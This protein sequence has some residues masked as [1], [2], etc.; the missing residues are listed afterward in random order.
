MFDEDGRLVSSGG[1]SGTSQEDDVAPL[2][3]PANAPAPENDGLPAKKSLV[4]K[5]DSDEDEDFGELGERALAD[6]QLKHVRKRGQ[7]STTTTTPI[8]LSRLGHTV[9][10][11]RTVQ[12][13]SGHKLDMVLSD[14]TKRRQRID[15]T[16]ARSAESN[17]KTEVQEDNF[18]KMVREYCLRLWHADVPFHL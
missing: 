15:T 13:A 1:P 12:K 9:Q 10:E 7:A 8:A 4:R 2:P 5:L 14:A 6:A 3:P 16:I 11:L 18:L 17:K